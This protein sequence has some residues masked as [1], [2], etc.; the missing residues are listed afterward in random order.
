MPSS[1]VPSNIQYSSILSIDHWMC[2]SLFC[3]Q[4]CSTCLHAPHWKVRLSSLVEPMVMQTISRCGLLTPPRQSKYFGACA[5][6]KPAVTIKCA[7]IWQVVVRA[8]PSSSDEAGQRE[9]IHVHD[10]KTL[11]FTSSGEE[12]RVSFDYAADGHVSQLQFFRGICT[13]VTSLHLLCLPIFICC[14]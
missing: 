7:N 6:L 10:T 14:V 11:S 5:L 2:C 12:S 9:A 1:C 13:S 4:G 3:S 8:R